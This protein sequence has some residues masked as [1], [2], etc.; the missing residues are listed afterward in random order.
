MARS[1][2]YVIAA[3]GR[4]DFPL[5]RPELFRTAR[6]IG[7]MPF[8]PGLRCRQENPAG[9]NHAER[10]HRLQPPRR[11]CLSE[12]VSQHVLRIGLAHIVVLSDGD[13][14]LRLHLGNQQMRTVCRGCRESAAVERRSGADTIGNS[15]C[16][17]HHDRST[18]TV[19]RRA[20]LPVFCYR[21][22][23]IQK[24]DERFRSV[25]CVVGFSALAIGRTTAFTAGSLKLVPS[26][27][28]GAFFC[29]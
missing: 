23:T 29:R 19:A 24:G 1:A 20:Y 9:T 5:L 3:S 7:S 8:P 2:K 22:L 26:G 14:E 13:Q 15:R 12:A 11:V 18:H 16:R 21:R 27:T 28:T 10:R 6:A 17:A 4:G 25:V